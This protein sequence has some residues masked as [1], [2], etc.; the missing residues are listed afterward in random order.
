[1]GHVKPVIVAP[2]RADLIKSLTIPRTHKSEPF[3]LWAHRVQEG[4]SQNTGIYSEK[5]LATYLQ[6]FFVDS[7]LRY[8]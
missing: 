8:T 4:I 7:K 1:M 3:S 2:N 5:R 6:G